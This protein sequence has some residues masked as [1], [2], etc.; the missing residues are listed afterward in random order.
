VRRATLLATFALP[1][2]LASFFALP[3]PDPSPSADFDDRPAS[4]YVWDCHVDPSITAALS[5]LGE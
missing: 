2:A 1:L 4:A 3:R 5:Q